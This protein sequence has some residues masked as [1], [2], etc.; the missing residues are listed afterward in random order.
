MILNLESANVLAWLKLKNLVWQPK[1]SLDEGLRR[2][3]GWVERALREKGI[4]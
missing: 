1:V 2:T 4:D 3:Y